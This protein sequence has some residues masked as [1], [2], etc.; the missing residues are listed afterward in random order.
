MLWGWGVD[1]NKKSDYKKSES[2]TMKFLNDNT[3]K[4]NNLAQEYLID[5]NLESKKYKIVYLI[6]Y[7]DIDDIHNEK[8]ETVQFECGSQGM[9]G[10][11]YWGLL[12][13]PDNHYLGEKDLYIY[14]EH[15]EKGNGNNIFIR[16]KL[17][18]NW[19]FYYDDYDG[20]IN[21]N[22]VK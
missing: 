6:A 5:H 2:Q 9:L 15:Q 10:G 13:I 21:I 7:R 11:Q 20:K 22:D 1:G 17:K 16:K 19:F 3:D 18:D 4:L 12:Y 14:N 8:L